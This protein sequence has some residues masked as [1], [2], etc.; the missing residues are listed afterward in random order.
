M[1]GSLLAAAGVVFA[2]PEATAH[3]GPQ[4][5]CPA[6]SDGTDGG[7]AGQRG[8]PPPMVGEGRPVRA[9]RLR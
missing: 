9:G 2:T 7:C 3:P 1:A 5:T 8:R 6:R 4:A